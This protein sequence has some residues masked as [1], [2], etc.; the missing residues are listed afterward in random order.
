MGVDLGNH[1]NMD[2]SDPHAISY[3]AAADHRGLGRP[4]GIRQADRASHL[5]VVGKTGTGKSTLLQTMALQD[6]RAGR[7]F[8]V[9][10]PHGDLIADL[11]RETAG[12]ERV[13]LLD[14][15]AANWT[16]NPLSG[17]APGQESLATAEI[18]EVFRKLWADDWGPRLEHLLRNVVFT[19]L[20]IPDSTLA[21]ASRLMTDKDLR[22]QVAERLE[23]EEVRE[24]WL[25]EYAR[26]S[27]AF[28]AVVTAP[29]QNKL[30]A[31]LTDPRVRSILGA[32]RSSFDLREVM[33]TGKVLLVNL[34]RGQI[35]EGPA[36][37]LGAFLAAHIGLVGL[38][39]ADRAEASRRPFY[40][41]LDE[42]Q[43]FATRS[44]ASM[45]SELRK[46]RVCLTLANQ[47]F[48]QL[49][50][51]VRDAVVGNVGTLI[52][53]RVSATDASYLAR[54]FEPVFSLADLVA[55]PNFHIYLRLMID[56]EVS[57]PFSARTLPA[58][59]RQ[60]SSEKRLRT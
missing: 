60:E 6:L 55:L 10:D 37:V 28:R 12:D 47:Y 56:R 13:I 38:A 15:H 9:F 39:R 3:F 20:E 49:D 36:Q 45:L 24:F 27:P 35:G 17:V 31:L 59:P 8:A 41:F 22:E 21:D 19:L 52:S 40:V 4:F 50:P 33:D 32:K 44:L 25:K 48:S 29:L 5:Y 14:A 30:G 51:G 1:D 7:G 34:S 53:F 11:R 58:P 26:Y 43:M 16:F 46:Y 54:E 23:N 57:R 2:A 18:V 42:F